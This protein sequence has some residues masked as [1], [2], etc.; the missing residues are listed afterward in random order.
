[1]PYF[2]LS[3][4]CGINVGNGHSIPIHGFGHTNLPSSNPPLVFLNVLYAPQIF[5]NLVYVLRFITDNLV[6]LEFDPLGFFVKDLKTRMHLMRCDSHGNLYP[7]TTTPTSQ[8]ASPFVLV[9]VTPS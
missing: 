2:N 8:V 4:N 1:M 6:S 3:S 9:V 7:F 5:K